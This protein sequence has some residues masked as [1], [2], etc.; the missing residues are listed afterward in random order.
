MTRP[1]RVLILHDYGGARGGA[2]LLAL[3]FR[4][5]LR[6]RGVEARL[7]ASDADAWTPDTAPDSTFSGAH[8]KLRPLRELYNPSAAAALRRELR[9][10]RPDVVQIVM[11][12]SQ[13]SPA[14]LPLLADVPTVYNVNTYRAVCP[15]GLR[16]RPD[17]GICTVTAGRDC[18]GKGCLSRAGLPF[19]LGQLALLER[20]RGSIDR[21]V[22]P[23]VVMAE[24]MA[25]HGFPVTDVI[26]TAFRCMSVPDRWGTHR[27]RPIPAA[28]FPKR[29][30]SG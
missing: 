22:S 27:W 17:V 25:R 19:R 18:Q 6:A 1:S 7:L 28:S 10:F 16:W 24:I 23:S 4:R 12:L 3:D 13:L 29:G 21:T 11:F 30:W 14:I 9:A 20:W 26:P 15:T 5:L 2:E 8:D